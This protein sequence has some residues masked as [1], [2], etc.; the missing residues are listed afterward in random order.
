[1]DSTKNG[2]SGKASFKADNSAYM[3]VREVYLKALAR[4]RYDLY[5]SNFDLGNLG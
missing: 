1:M 2:G 3:Q 5:K 4:E